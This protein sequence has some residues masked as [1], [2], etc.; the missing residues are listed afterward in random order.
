V[1]VKA[2]AANE[3]LCSAWQQTHDPKIR[4]KLTRRNMGLVGKFAR[5]HHRPE[6]YDDLVQ[7]GCLGLLRAFDE[8][9]PSHDVLLTT[10]AAWWI[11]AYQ[12]RWCVLFHRIVKFG[13]TK[14]QRKMFSSLRRARIE[15]ESAGLEVNG[16]NVARVLGLDVKRATESLARLSGSD[17]S[18][19]PETTMLDGMK[20]EATAERD[21]IEAELMYLLL[22]EARAY[23][24]GLSAR[25]RD[26]FDAR[27]FE[28]DKATLQEIGDR[29]SI[30]RERVRQIE[31]RALQRL[32]IRVLARTG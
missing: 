25:E 29:Y 27:F 20:T 17:V 3:Q 14:T 9:D 1:L 12:K 13:T 10:Y 8:W 19:D 26:I 5:E 2:P 32:K 23:R 24:Q 6:H 22:S 28:D 4:D 31:A 16:E 15:L 18:L 30:S 21:V 11:K 7:E